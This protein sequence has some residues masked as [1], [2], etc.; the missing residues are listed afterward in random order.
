MAPTPRRPP[1]KQP[2]KRP[3][4]DGWRQHGQQQPEYGTMHPTSWLMNIDGGGIQKAP[5]APATCMC[6]SE[7]VRPCPLGI[8]EDSCT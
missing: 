7:S 5:V 6:H 2:P 8:H 3:E 1:P 4:T